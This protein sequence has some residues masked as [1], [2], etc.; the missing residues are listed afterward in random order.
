MVDLM[1]K[2]NPNYLSVKVLYS[3]PWNWRV[4]YLRISNILKQYR[5]L[6]VIIQ[7]LN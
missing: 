1:E 5:N 6:H 3:G 7:T 2:L 4:I